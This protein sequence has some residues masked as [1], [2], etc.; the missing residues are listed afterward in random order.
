MIVQ[1]VAEGFALGISSG[2]VCAGSC[3]PFI[4]PYLLMDSRP[5]VRANLPLFI[6]FLAGRLLAY[7]LFGA[8]VGWIG[9]EVKPY[10][11]GEVHAASLIATSFLMIL[12]SL[13]VTFHENPLCAF[14]ARHRFWK[15]F[16]FFLGFF[17]G[18]N[19]CPPFLVGVAR[20]LEVGS[21]LLGA[22][23]F[24]AFFLATSLYLVP[25]FVVLPL[26]STER[27]RAVGTL[28]SFLVG[29]YYLIFGIISLI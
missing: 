10:L 6:R 4:V 24:T 29:A 8:F 5:G 25:I 17:L 22:L 9:Q 16:P 3:A 21:V 7:V 1:A 2:I 14:A 12:F 26:I 28:V 13:G 11:S 18:L 15:R 19:I 23:F 27:L 20:L